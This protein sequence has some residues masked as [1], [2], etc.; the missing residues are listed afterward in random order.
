MYNGLPILLGILLIT[1]L[2]PAARAETAGSSEPLP[3][4]G[5]TASSLSPISTA[6]DSETG[7]AGAA[8]QAS[9]KSPGHSGSGDGRTGF[10]VVGMLVN[11]AV[12]A[13]F[14]AWAVKEWRRKR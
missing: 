3:D 5:Y 8:A 4:H 2:A 10:W 14:L 13:W 1:L 12:L 6:T 11:L 7:A 9:G